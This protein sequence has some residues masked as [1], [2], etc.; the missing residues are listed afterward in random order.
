M[1]A[2]VWQKAA[3]R[4][5]M[6]IRK[7]TR[8]TIA[9]V[10]V[11]EDGIL[12]PDAPMLCRL[13]NAG[14][15]ECAHCRKSHV[16]LRREAVATSQPQRSICPSGMAL[17]AVPMG[18]GSVLEGGR[19]FT[20]RPGEHFF[21][22]V[23][24][25][26]RPQLSRNQLDLWRAS[27][28]QIPIM[29]EEELE[30]AI[31]LVRCVAEGLAGSQEAVGAK[32]SPVVPP[33]IERAKSYVDAHLGGELNVTVAARVACLSED[34]FSKL[35]K[36]TI[37]MGFAE[38]VA[39]ARVQWAQRLLL[40]GSSKHISEVAYECGFESVP[41]FNRQF[42]RVT[43]V[44]PGVFRAEYRRNAPVLGKGDRSVNSE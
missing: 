6:P 43:G 17:F 29:S 2:P 25:R 28:L 27:W 32:P 4:W 23:S 31:A 12:S 24:S 5:L 30:A 11:G 18:G 21:Q 10:P 9:Y 36:R 8:V 3:E 16:E 33:Q 37:G 35:F 42:K 38:Y 34:Y 41:H 40:S 7:L 14:E 19:V 39:Q 15:T 20:L 1:P 44:A 13:V 26:L 22:E